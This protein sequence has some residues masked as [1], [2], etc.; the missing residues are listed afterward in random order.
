MKKAL[1]DS[2]TSRVVQVADAE[3]EVHGALY[4]VDCPDTTDGF[5][6]YDPVEKTF[7]DPHAH[8]KDEYGNPVEPFTM[9]RMRAYPPSGDQ[10]DMLWKELRDT[11]TI[12][13]D[14]KWY[15]AIHAVKQAVPKPIDPSVNVQ[16]LHTDGTTAT[17]YSEVPASRTTGTGRNGQVKFRKT[18]DQLQVAVETPG[19]GYAVDNIITIP[20]SDVEESV[21]ISLRVVQT[22]PGGGLVRV[23]IV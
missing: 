3:F 16:V 22:D 11:G 2:T 12:S 10:L 4:W 8:N 13:K 18:T 9:Q 23:E 20:G 6:L 21:D 1:I 7:T 19:L 14:G 15:Q 17:F 5:Y